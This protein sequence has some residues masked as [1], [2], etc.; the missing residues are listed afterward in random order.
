M[1]IA[2]FLFV[3]L[4]LG[5]LGQAVVF[6]KSDTKKEYQALALANVSAVLGVVLAVYGLGVLN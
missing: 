4:A 2:T 6:S 5:F 1:L 3:V